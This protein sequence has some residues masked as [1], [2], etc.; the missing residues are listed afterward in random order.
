MASF[1]PPC[2]EETPIQEWLS[3][4]AH[5]F[6][7]FPVASAACW[8]LPLQAVPDFGSDQALLTRLLVCHRALGNLE[9]MATLYKSRLGEMSMDDPK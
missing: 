6:L 3:E 5:G 1:C 2:S 9:P 8:C 4:R 7:P